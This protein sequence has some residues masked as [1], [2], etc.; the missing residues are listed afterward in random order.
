MKMNNIDRDILHVLSESG[1]HK[2]EHKQKLYDIVCR[3]RYTKGQFNYSL[4]KLKEEGLIKSAPVRGVYRITEKGIENIKNGETD[5]KKGFEEE[6]WTHTGGVKKLGNGLVAKPLVGRHRTIYAHGSQNIEYPTH[7]YE[8]LKD[9]EGLPHI[10]QNVEKRTIDGI[11]HLVREDLLILED[12]DYKTLR[13]RDL[14]E[15]EKT[16]RKVHKRGWTICDN[17]QIGYSPKQNEY[18]IYDWSNAHKLEGKERDYDHFIVRDDMS[19]NRLW[20][21]SGFSG[22]AKARSWADS[23]RFKQ[24]WNAEVKQAEKGIPPKDRKIPQLN[25]TYMSYARPP[26]F[27][28][29]EY[30]EGDLIVQDITQKEQWQPLGLI[31]TEKRLTEKQ[32]YDAELTPTKYEVIN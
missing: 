28:G 3:V 16:I 1:N 31:H 5:E 21:E 17:I 8:V 4:K 2:S 6:K 11:P 22:Y 27:L 14:I 24:K 18:V 26:H 9:L 30:P 7:E 32:I 20:E 29:I 10:P 13:E 19:L 23:E 15:F 25:Y 12:E